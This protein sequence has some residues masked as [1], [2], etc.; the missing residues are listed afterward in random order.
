M[1][2]NYSIP[3]DKQT[4]ILFLILSASIAFLFTGCSQ[5]IPP[6]IS[7]EPDQQSAVPDLIE[8]D[9]LSTVT[10][11]VEVPAD[12]PPGNTVLLSLLDEVTGLALNINRREM[13]QIEDSIYAITLPF[14]VG[15][16]IKYR[17]SRQGDSIFEEHTTDQRPVRYRIYRVDGP[18]IVKDIVSSWSDGA[19]D[20]ST[21]RIMGRVTNQESGFPIPNLLVSAGGAQTVTS[22]RG[23]YLL[24]GLPPG[25]HNLVLYAFDGGYRTYQQGAVVA[26]NSTTPA[27]IQLTPAP[28]VKLIF[29]ATV[30]E[31]T[32]P[33]VPIRLAGNLDQLGN[34]FAD[35]SG[36]VNTLAARMP[37]LIPLQDGR[38]AL[39]IELPAGAF[40]EYKYTLGD[41][42]WNSEYTPNGDFRIRTLTVPDVDTVI[43]DHIDNWG[44]NSSAGP[45]LFD[46]MVPP[47][48]PDFDHV[49]IQFNP[50][51]WTEPIPM[52]KLGED[53]WVYMLFSP[54]AQFEQIVYRY[55]RNDQC[56]RA[57]DD[58]TP[59]N[60]PAGRT[61][62]IT[63]GTQ[64]IED[65][66]ESWFWMEPADPIED[67]EPSE[68]KPRADG[69]INGVQFQ[70]YHHPSI[71]PRFPVSFREIN[72][73]GANWVFLTPT[74]TYTRQ[75]PP[76]LESVTGKDIS[77]SDLTSISEKARSFDLH[78]AYYPAPNFPEGY[79]DWWSSSP[80]DFPWWR[81]WF[82]RYNN[83][84]LTFADKAQQ[85][86]AKGLVIGGDW[87]SPALPG[88]MLPD[89]SPSG[90]P[91]DAEDRWRKIIS[92]VRERY[93]GTLFWALPAT[94]TGIN[95]PPF[96]E[97]LDQVYL[98]WSLPLTDQSDT[99]LPQLSNTAAE[100]L[101]SE[102]ALVDISLEMPIVVAAGYP[103]AN[104]SL[105]GCLVV[106]DE[107][108]EN[109]CFDP[110]NL[111]PP[112]PD[113]MEVVTN[114][115]EQSLA[116]SALLMAVNERDW[117]DGFVSTGFYS[118]A[119]LRDKST[120]IHGKP[121]QAELKSWFKGFLPVLA[122]GE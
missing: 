60:S 61:I 42:F 2:N 12:T 112:H 91:A 87:I 116:Y 67:G 108:G 120:S 10:F 82:E 114:L 99:T 59:G 31:G 57:D 118:P 75:T 103:S 56:G 18:G 4:L 98:H 32:L 45:I 117:I 83:F 35:L 48:T 110:I 1:K 54:I 16:N 30:P 95:P 55:C 40:L 50:F 34:T 109:S 90:V 97:D 74:W 49:S 102:V 9:P 77:W 24:E 96:I 119:E 81:V 36:G 89:G 43:E 106:I 73:L 94:N 121:T 28:L 13:Q 39:E 51:G 19:Y 115:E 26:E 86:G 105:Q 65:T 17:Y 85:D 44:E 25:L 27:D 122:T 68:V 29:T 11:Q 71:T 33:A 52:W 21:G 20:K 14:P 100:Y 5:S 101:D 46:L 58:L 88:G 78:V 69:F 104:G 62:D 70:K 41:G 64:T 93:Q 80:R 72:T 107:S 6:V 111:E 23:D 7:F 3:L 22:S 66:I 37:T 38:Y 79:T 84:I 53:H 63:G 76:L 15:A 92:D 8:I 47:S 113:N